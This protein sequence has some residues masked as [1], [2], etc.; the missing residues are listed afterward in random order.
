[1]T[2]KLLAAQVSTAKRRLAASRQ[3]LALADEKPV[4]VSLVQWLVMRYK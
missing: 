1:M 2:Q 4:W 3:A